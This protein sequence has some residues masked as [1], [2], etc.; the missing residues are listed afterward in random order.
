[1]QV[2][3]QRYVVLVISHKSS[4]QVD[5]PENSVKRA[6]NYRISLA[7]WLCDNA[8]LED[9]GDHQIDDQRSQI[10]PIWQRRGTG[11]HVRL[12]LKPVCVDKSRD[13]G[14]LE[15]GIPIPVYRLLVSWDVQAA[16]AICD[17]KCARGNKGEKCPLDKTSK[18]WATCSSGGEASSR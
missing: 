9:M 1:M 7:F 11:L 8:S 5:E 14:I 3:C 16:C 13:N 15:P 4:C 18:P 12:N 17:G 6:Q 10:D 2:A